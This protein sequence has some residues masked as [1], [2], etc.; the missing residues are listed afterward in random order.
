MNSHSFLE[1][2]DSTFRGGV[3]M[4]QSK[5]VNPTSGCIHCYT[6]PTNVGWIECIY[7]VKFGWFLSSDGT[8]VSNMFDDGFQNTI[9][10]FSKFGCG[11]RV[12]FW[13]CQTGKC[14]YQLCEVI[15][16]WCFMASLMVLLFWAF[17]TAFSRTMLHIMLTIRQ[18]IRTAE[19]SV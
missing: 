6:K 12:C 2:L 8:V 15:G 11:Q 5:V 14:D 9:I 3:H 17:W 18:Y 1:F 16:A 13:G 19:V 7:H 4:H 10:H